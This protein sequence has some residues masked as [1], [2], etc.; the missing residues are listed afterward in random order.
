MAPWVVTR[1]LGTGLQLYQI[2]AVQD[3]KSTAHML[4]PI[5]PR[6]WHAIPLIPAVGE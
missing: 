1:Q 4:I 6:E 5:F 3:Y 2:T